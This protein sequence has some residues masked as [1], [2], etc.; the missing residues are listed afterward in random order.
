MASDTRDRILAALRTMLARCGP[1]GITLEGVAAEAGV[2][3]GGLLYHFPS[4][5]ALYLGLLESVRDTVAA[6]M[7]ALIDEVGPVR[8][9]LQYAAPTPEEN[10][11]SAAAAL[12]AAV[13]S[14]RDV[15]PQAQELFAEGFRVWEEPMRSAV[16][17]PVQA[18]IIRLVG[19][20][21]YLSSISG[22]PQPD[23]ALLVQVVDRLV[24]SL[25]V[26]AAG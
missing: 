14:G 8:A 4:K 23:P 13:R 11:T 21:I 17:D 26:T 12:I 16:A 24:E 15:D 5:A 3:K 7:A 2:S 18:E 9:F 22:L 20:G 6:D 25:D 19:N 10:E 1:D